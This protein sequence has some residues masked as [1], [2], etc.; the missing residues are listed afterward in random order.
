MG[1][2][3]TGSDC[4]FSHGEASK[5]ERT[6]RKKGSNNGTFQETLGD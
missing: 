4:L 3:I 2:F 6:Q 1:A 5:K